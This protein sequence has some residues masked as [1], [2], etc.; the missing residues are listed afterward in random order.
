MKILQAN[1]ENINRAAKVIMKGGIVIYPTDTVYGLGGLP[2]NP[3]TTERICNIKGRTTKPLPL[4]CSENVEAEKIVIFNEE[5][6]ILSQHFWPG[7]LM[8]ILQSKVQ[9]PKWVTQNSK[10]LGV[11]VP[12]HNI[13]RQLAHTSGGVIVSTSANRTGGK[14]PRTV[15]EAIDQIGSEVDLILDAGILSQ[16]KPSTIIDLST[17]S[18]KLLREGPITLEQ[19]ERALKSQG[20]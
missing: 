14:P 12:D 1:T 17:R 20:K 16:N 2:S 19:I 18:V 15:K 9:Y 4:I 11:R 8:L 10:N 5:A 3:K 7:Q 13:A 6:R